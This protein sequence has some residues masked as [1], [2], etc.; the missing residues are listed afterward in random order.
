MSFKKERDDNDPTDSI[1]A[2]DGEWK[3]PFSVPFSHDVKPIKIDRISRRFCLKAFCWNSISTHNY[4]CD[5]LISA[6]SVWKLLKKH[7]KSHFTALERVKLIANAKIA[8][9]VNLASFLGKIACAQTEL[10]DRSTVNQTNIDEKCQNR[11]FKWDFLEWFPSTVKICLHA[12]FTKWGEF[13]ITFYYRNET[14]CE[15]FKTQCI[16]FLWRQH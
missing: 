1:Y 7:K 13:K 16:S 4:I 15:N 6:H 5:I 12:L 14:Y 11:K 10:A 2:G 8:K 3:E 9:I